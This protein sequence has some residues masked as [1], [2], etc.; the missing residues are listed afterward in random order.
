MLREAPARMTA[1]RPRA[2]AP[3]LHHTAAL[4]VPGE[5]R[6]AAVELGNRGTSK[7]VLPGAACSVPGK[8]GDPGKGGVSIVSG[9][10]YFP[11]F[12]SVS[13]FLRFHL[14]G[15]RFFRGWNISIP[16]GIF[17]RI[18]GYHFS[19]RTYSST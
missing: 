8:G 19:V 17:L 2:T 18:S 14:Y 3:L 9:G 6:S 16:L 7:G 4:G 13:S 1:T 11:G 5:R 15:R 12:F 10:V